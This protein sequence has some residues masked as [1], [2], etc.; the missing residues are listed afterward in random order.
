MGYFFGDLKKLLMKYNIIYLQM[1]S[2]L[3]S[4]THCLDVNLNDQKQ[5]VEMADLLVILID[6]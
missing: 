3:P 5:S 1:N 6:I 4:Y 2:F